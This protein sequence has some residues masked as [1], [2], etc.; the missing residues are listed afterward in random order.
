MRA[1]LLVF[2]IA[3]C[4]SAQSSPDGVEPA[5]A[6]CPVGCTQVG[7]SCSCCPL[8]FDTTGQGFQ[9]TD[10]AHGVYFRLGPNGPKYAM[11]G[12]IL[13]GGTD[14]LSCPM[15]TAR[16]MISRT[17]SAARARSRRPPTPTD[18]WLW[19]CMTYRAKAATATDGLILAMRFGRSCG[20]GL[21]PTRTAKRSHGSFIRWVPWVSSASHWAT[22]SQ[23][24]WTNTATSSDM[25]R[26]S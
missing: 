3:A 9:M 18:T 12:P 6:C 23:R 13:P 7:T 16:C 20:C 17:S 26:K 10:I 8:V 1:K 22:S 19:Q 25:C 21:M 15:R 24:K 2:L 11:L 4:A 5:D 14:G